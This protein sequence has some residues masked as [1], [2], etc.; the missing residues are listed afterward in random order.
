MNKYIIYSRKSSEAEDRQI[1]SLPSQIKE[2]KKLARDQGLSATEM[3]PESKSAKAPGRE[4]FNQM[5]DKIETDGISGIVCWKLDRLARNPVDG[6]RIIWAVN[7]IGIQIITP[8]KTYTTNDLLLMYVEF[9]MANQ[10]IS[11]LSKNVKRGLKAKAEKGW[12]P[13]GAKPG[14]MND[15]YAEKGSKTVQSDPKRFPL[16]R[17]CWELMLTGLYSP[18]QI[19]KRLNNEWGYRT[20]KHRKIGGKPMSRSM[21]YKVFND[22]FYYGE[23]E[24]GGVW[25]KGRHEPMITK[26]E[27]DRVQI[28]LGK[29]G[30]PKPKTQTFFATGLIRCGECGACITAEEKWQV[31]CTV[32]KHKFSSKNRSDCPKCGTT[33][34]DMK[35]P[36]ILH[37]IYYH[38]TKRK[39]PN[40][41]QGC[42]TENELTKQIDT[43]LSKVRISER[44][45]NWAIKYLNELNDQ[46]VDDRTAVLSSLETAYN[47][48]VKRIDNLV[49]LKIS[50]Q[51]TD[52]SVLS[53]GEFKSQKTSLMGEK[54]SLEEKLKDCGQ[55]ISRWV[56]LSEKTFNFACYAQHW[57][58][59]G[60]LTTKRQILQGLGSNIILK[61]KILTI[62]L[63]KPL[64]FIEEAVD[65]VIEISPKFEPKKC[66]DKTGQLEDYF[67]QNTTM[68]RGEDS[69]LQP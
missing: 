31:I 68:L 61:D 21:I 5:M 56:E 36:T 39:N 16:I 51:N 66:P 24:Y 28:L 62:E 44:F 6:G 10:F 17:K 50:P 29:K 41:T 34:E 38:C 64:Q 67:S 19:L 57:F 46:E 14:Y 65:K 53:D 7:H 40:C 1:L 49:R 45:K 59:S 8:Q 13:S 27:F 22:P 15:K 37:Y 54:T 11:D 20:P 58:A 26:E 55:R 4:I 35:H 25:Y 69:N 3:P 23:F 60:D 18:P 12:L 43:Y 47:D 9:G 33:I 42:I 63:E 2:L 32:C 52:G 48:C 30:R